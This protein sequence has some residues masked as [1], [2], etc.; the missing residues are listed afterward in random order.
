MIPR[1]VT[2]LP[3][4][5]P[6]ILHHPWW[7]FF[8]PLRTRHL[9]ITPVPLFQSL[10]FDWQASCH[11]HYTQLVLW[12]DSSL[13]IQLAMQISTAFAIHY[14]TP[15]VITTFISLFDHGYQSMSAHT[16]DLRSLQKHTHHTLTSIPP[17]SP[18][19]FS[20]M[21]WQPNYACSCCHRCCPYHFSITNNQW[22]SFHFG[23][24][25]SDLTCA[26]SIETS[27]IWY[28]HSLKGCVVKSGPSS[29]F[30]IFLLFFLILLAHIFPF[31]TLLL[32]VCHLVSSITNDHILS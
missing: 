9:D 6:C 3:G 8:C 29:I 16:F 28:Q 31:V 17:L 15:L 20:L 21:I 5:V 32:L 22:H 4:L 13:P 23:T 11:V 2:H 7:Y 25:D 30:P 18:A 1:G 14:S 24:A 26:N 27:F 10:R 12:L 19:N